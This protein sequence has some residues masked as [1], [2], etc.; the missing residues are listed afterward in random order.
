MIYGY[1]RISTSD[2]KLDMQVDALQSAGAVEIYTDT[3]T[4]TAKNREGLDELLSILVAGDVVLVWKLDRLGRSVRNLLELAEILKSKG[5]SVRSLQDGID[6]S[7]PLGGFLLTILG[8]VGELER[9]TIR[10][11]VQAG[12]SAGRRRGEHQG[13]KPKL[14]RLARQDVVDSVANG[15]PAKDLARRYGVNVA[16]IYRIL[17][18][19]VQGIERGDRLTRKQMTTI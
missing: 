8:A 12:M 9:E 4:G 10:E 5:V 7:G 18:D 15:S 11:R 19:A 16:T 1:A 17:S 3:I 6:T 14:S 2:Q 13:R